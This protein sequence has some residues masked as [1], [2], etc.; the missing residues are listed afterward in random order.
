MKNIIENVQMIAVYA[1]L[2]I[3]V[4]ITFRSLYGLFASGTYGNKDRILSNFFIIFLGAQFLSELLLFLTTK[5]RYEESIRASEHI[6]LTFF[7]L[8]M[9]IGGRIIATKSSD[10]SV[11]FR[12]RSIYYGVA[13]GLLLYAFVLAFP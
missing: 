2:L 1:N 5:Y 6:T 12:F 7:A 11:K 3:G 13:T 4:F 9:T 10:H 8:V